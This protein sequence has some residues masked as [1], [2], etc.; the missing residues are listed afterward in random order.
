M[1]V[2]NRKLDDWKK[3]MIPYRKWQAKKQLKD[4]RAKQAKINKEIENITSDAVEL[5]VR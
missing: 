2:Y 3:H 1:A 4:L 5:G